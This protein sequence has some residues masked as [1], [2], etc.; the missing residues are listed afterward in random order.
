MPTPNYKAAIREVVT[1]LENGENA[2]VPIPGGDLSP[3]AILR[4]DPVLVTKWIPSRRM[5]GAF[6]WDHRKMRILRRGQPLLWGILL[7]GEFRVGFGAAV[8]R[9]TAIRAARIYPDQVIGVD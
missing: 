3:Y 7:D 4:G 9:R 1:A 6:L 8:N 5:V 2:L